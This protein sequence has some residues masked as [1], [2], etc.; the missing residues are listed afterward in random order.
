M[1]KVFL[2][3]LKRVLL[4]RVFLVLLVVNGIYAWF[5]LSTDI[6]V[7]VAYTAPFSV[8]S[9]CVYSGKVILFEIITTLLML[10]GYYGKKQKQ[11]EIL[12]SATPITPIKQLLIRSGVL[13][14]CFFV[15]YVLAVI[16]ADVF[17]IRLFKYNNF[18]RFFLPALLIAVPCFVCSVGLGH[19][20]GRLHRG[21]IYLL[22][23]AAFV[24]GGSITKVFD[25]FGAGYFQTYPLTLI[26]NNDGEP[27]FYL[28]PVWLTM[29]LLYLLVGILLLAF[30]SIT[31]E[32]KSG[33]A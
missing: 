2:Y 1:S 33:M 9:F 6:V 15:L 18:G 27:D 8:W 30:I 26:V 14:V 17:Y 5:V 31:A 28:S 20:L 12:I 7:G 24:A 32:R 13:A 11:V 10:S 29:R 19:L 25:F 4:N 16:L 21:L 22:I 23:V 3:E